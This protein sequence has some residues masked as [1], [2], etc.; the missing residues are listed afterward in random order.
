MIDAELISMAYEITTFLPAFNQR[1]LSFRIN[2]T[3]FLRA[4]LMNN[5]VPTDKYLDI[6]AAVLD[7]IDRKISKFQLHSTITALLSSR[8]S[9]SNLIDILLTEFPIGG[10][11]SFYANGTSLRNLLKGHSEASMLARNAM[12][13]IEAVVALAQSLGVVVCSCMIL[14]LI[15]IFN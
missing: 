11:K 7:Y 9:S 6:F 1:N 14:K 12:D 10:S 3:T 5:N 15:M 2:H 13:E 4:I 8:H